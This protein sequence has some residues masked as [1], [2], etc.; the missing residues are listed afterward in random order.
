[1]TL[2]HT[3]PLTGWDGLLSKHPTKPSLRPYVQ[4]WRTH[5]HYQLWTALT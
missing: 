2:G 1:M 4:L 5:V 3:S